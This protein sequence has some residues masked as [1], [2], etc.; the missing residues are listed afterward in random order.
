MRKL[1]FSLICLV[2]L[3]TFARAQRIDKPTLTPKPCT[4]T[5]KQT[6]QE[7]IGLHDAK[8]YA[9]AAEKYQQVLAENADCTLALYELAMTYDTLGDKTKA[10]E[11]AYKGSKYKSDELPLFYQIMANVIDD[12]GKPDEAVRIYRDGNKMLEG[13]PT[14][15][16]HLSSMHYNLGVTYVRQKKYAESREELKK[17]VIYNFKY[18]SP[19][20]LLAIVYNGTKY[21]VPAFLAASRLVS[22]DLTSSRTQQAAAIIRDVLKPAPKDPKTGNTQIFLSLDAPKDEGDFGMYDLML[23]TLGMVKDEKDKNKSESEMFVSAVDTVISLLAED[24]KLASTFVGKNYIPFMLELKKRGHVPT[25][26]YAVLYA[27]GDADALKWLQQNEA[28]LNDFAAWAK[29]YQ[30]PK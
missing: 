22:L 25:F 9:E 8:K 27:S 15:L 14:M 7:G 30:L 11:T 13:D 3:S 17:A 1:L 5:Q 23:G 26:A 19:H 29:E 24:K 20:Y 10:M 21:K 12:V 28:R 2:L 16:P 4:D 6:I 18:P